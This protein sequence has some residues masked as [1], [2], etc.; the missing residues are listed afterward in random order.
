MTPTTTPC[1]T[2]VQDL[3]TAD[4]A[5][6]TREQPVELNLRVAQAHFHNENPDD[7]DEAIAL[8]GP[9]VVWEAALRGQVYTD[10][11]DAKQ[12][13]LALFSALRF[14]RLI[15]LRRFATDRFVFD[16]QIADLTVVGDGM[17][18]LGFRPGMRLVHCSSSSTARP[19]VRSRTRCRG[20]TADPATT[21]TSP[22]TPSCRSSRPTPRSPSRPEQQWAPRTQ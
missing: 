17:P 5:G 6:M 21:T 11:A 8:Y 2:T 7:A 10:P 19:P 9:D 14:N 13:Y 15:T 4:T 20:S 1:G 16:N 3:R 22:T 12:A 18:N